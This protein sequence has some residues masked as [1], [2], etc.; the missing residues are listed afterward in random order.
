MPNLSDPVK[1]YQL[2]QRLMTENYSVFFFIK[3][4]ES[5]G[6]GSVPEITER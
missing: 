2:K 6:V 1:N 3:S 4:M 5:T